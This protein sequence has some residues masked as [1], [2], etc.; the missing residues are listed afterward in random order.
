MFSLRFAAENEKPQVL[1]PDP[2]VV[3]PQ[4]EEEESVK[5]AM[6]AALS[7]KLVGWGVSVLMHAGLV[8][9]A[10]F[11]VWSYIE[12]L[13]EEEVIIPIAR[14]SE[15][16]GAP[17]TMTE[18]QRQQEQSSASQR[19]NITRTQTPQS[20]VQSKVTAQTQLIGLAGGA[21]SKAS[22]IGTAV[23]AGQDTGVGFYGTGGN[24]R[25][26]AYVVDASGSLMDS[27]PFVILELK[28]S[29]AELSEQQSF[30][31]VFY[32][33]GLDG[34]P[35]VIEGPTRGLKRADANNKQAVINWIDP[36]SGNVI[37]AGKTNPIAAIKQA[38]TYRPQL[39]FLLSDNITG[40]GIYE[41]DQK[42]L[43]G[44]IKRAN[45]D[46]TKINTIQF[47]YPDAL[48]NV[49]GMRGTLQ[50]IAEDTGGIYKFV[51]AHELGLS[52]R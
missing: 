27:L 30:T 49:P 2:D 1:P 45:R 35:K 33:V 6:A 52:I 13:N 8:L 25:R 41:L 50:L 28:R 12:K 26:I 10:W 44:D 15:M 14:L 46:N 36:A 22:P 48:G 23:G 38:L 29:I 3:R 5:E 42:T 40:D 24:A 11:L 9:L 18:M 43:L 32:Q 17:I 47:L 31:V 21:A 7:A 34:K 39:L 16:P 4:E 37:P 19:R 51:D 20:T